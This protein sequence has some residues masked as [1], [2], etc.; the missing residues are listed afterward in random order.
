[1]CVVQSTNSKGDTPVPIYSVAVT[2]EFIVVLGFGIE[3]KDGAPDGADGSEP[4]VDVSLENDERF[5]GVSS[6]RFLLR[7]G[8][9]GCRTGLL[10]PVATSLAVSITHLLHPSV[11]QTPSSA[12]APIFF[13]SRKYSNVVVHAEL[14]LIPTYTIH[15]A[16]N[17][18][19]AS[20]YAKHET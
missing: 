8:W 19:D 20:P 12:E 14:Y 9:S 3:I 4:F 10:L 7:L 16:Y 6:C 18:Y 2:A 17:L 11:S 1:M 5:G 15:N 13:S